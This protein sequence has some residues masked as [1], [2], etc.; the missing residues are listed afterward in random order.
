MEDFGT[1]NEHHLVHADD[2]GGGYHG[3]CKY[4]DLALVTDLGY[5]SWEGTK[6][7][8]RK[9]TQPNSEIMGYA[10]F[11]GYTFSDGKFCKQYSDEE[12]SYQ[13]IKERYDRAIA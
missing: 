10:R 4:C 5:N 7:I 9:L 1:I 3:R 13:E 11:H 2:A 12:V 6:C 8:D